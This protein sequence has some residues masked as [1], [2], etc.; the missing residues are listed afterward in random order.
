VS[1]GGKLLGAAVPTVTY[2]IDLLS[3]MMTADSYNVS[4]PQ[5]G[6]V[7]IV[8][9]GDTNGSGSAHTIPGRPTIDHIDV[10]GS[11]AGKRVDVSYTVFYTDGHSVKGTAA[12]TTTG[13]RAAPAALGTNGA[14]TTADIASGAYAAGLLDAKSLTTI[15]GKPFDAPI[16]NGGRI[17]YDNGIDTSNGQVY[18][19]ARDY[20]VQY[21]VYVGANE[22]DTAA[23]WKK[24]NPGLATTP[25][26]WL[27]GFFFPG[28]GFYAELPTRVLLVQ[29][30]DLKAT[31]APTAQQSAMV[32]QWT[33]DVTT[34][35]VNSLKSG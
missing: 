26:P 3:F 9:G 24:Q 11:K 25:G 31:G 12:W 27:S 30:L 2:D 5:F 23:F 20:V 18:S 16:A 19:T 7:T 17:L 13:G 6:Q 10:N 15:F 4:S 29:V 32:T 35:I 14:P 34:A 33:I 1:F 21:T 28:A 8:P 22:A